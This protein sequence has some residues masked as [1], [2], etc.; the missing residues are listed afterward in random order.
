MNLFCFSDNQVS[1]SA[2][3]E[4]SIEE[5]RS[6]VSKRS[7]IIWD[8]KPDKV[9]LYSENVIQETEGTE[10]ISRES[11]ANLNTTRQQWETITKPKEE[12]TPQKPKQT[13]VRHWEVKL[14]T[15]LKRVPAKPEP[16]REDS[17]SDSESDDKMA[18][19][20]NANESA[21]E[22]EIRLA[23]ERE[24]MLR[25][26]HEERAELQV[27]QDASQLKTLNKE[28]F[29]SES[30]ELN[31]NK[32]TYHEMTEADRGSELQQ[33]EEQ[34][35]LELFEQEERELELQLKPDTNGFE[36]RACPHWIGGNQ[37][38]SNKSGSKID[39]NG[40]FNQTFCF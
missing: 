9:N 13:Q 1:Q 40:V 23:M 3:P 15:Q 22:R 7:S 19:T 18:D 38:H 12:T 21:I 14:P 35:Q 16:K 4:N 39:R 2:D 25:K 32:P 5:W 8:E 6:D 28:P 30:V 17:D 10:D 37:K 27:R 36:V 24:D 11:I 29:E 34:I 33:R 31:N 26:E 20:E